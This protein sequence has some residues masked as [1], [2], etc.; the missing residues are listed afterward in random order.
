MAAAGAG[1]EDRVAE[2]FCE[3]QIKAMRNQSGVQQSLEPGWLRQEQCTQEGLQQPPPPP[4]GPITGSMTHGHGA[5]QQ[6]TDGHGAWQQDTDGHG[7][8]QQDTDG[9]G[10]LQQHTDGHGALQQ[11]TDGHGAWQQYTDGHGAWQQ[12][13]HGHGAWQQEREA[14]SDGAACIDGIVGNNEYKARVQPLAKAEAAVCARTLSRAACCLFHRPPFRP[15]LFLR[16]ASPPFV[17]ALRLP[18]SSCGA[19]RS[20]PSAVRRPPNVY[21]SLLSRLTSLL[22]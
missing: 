9:H 1:S 14:P 3:R 22:T 6:H 2:H 18:C 4:A 10:A 17:F 5:W 8:W 13:T 7:A 15:L 11:Y 12:H 20:R 21:L 16:P 19:Q